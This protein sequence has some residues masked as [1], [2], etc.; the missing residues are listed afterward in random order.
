[1]STA[2]IN[3]GAGNAGL[4]A[5]GRGESIL[6]IMAHDEVLWRTAPGAGTEKQAETDAMEGMTAAGD[7][8]H[9]RTTAARMVNTTDIIE[10][11]VDLAMSN[12]RRSQA[13]EVTRSVRHCL[14]GRKQSPS[15]CGHHLTG[16]SQT[17]QVVVK[18]PRK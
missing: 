12:Q 8:P 6:T 14:Q 10:R 3:A 4:L 5:H 13:E 17:R 16:R 11:D 18:S 15:Q 2:D 7:R 9:R 1:M